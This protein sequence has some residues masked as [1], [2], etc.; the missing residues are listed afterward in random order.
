MRAVNRQP[1]FPRE[2]L[3]ET[4]EK[5]GL[6]HRPPNNATTCRAATRNRQER[7]QTTTTQT[8]VTP[9]VGPG[10]LVASNCKMKQCIPTCELTLTKT[11]TT[12]L[13]STRTLPITLT[14]KPMLEHDKRK[15]N[16]RVFHRG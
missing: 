16:G 9:N 5:Q 13:T 2:G 3:V 4:I 11:T 8:I 14:R 1:W 15:Y 6:Q 10:K 7:A 12:P